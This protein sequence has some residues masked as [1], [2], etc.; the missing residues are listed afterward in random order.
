MAARLSRSNGGSACI[1]RDGHDEN[2]KDEGNCPPRIFHI[3]CDKLEG[4]MDSL[5]PMLSNGKDND[6]NEVSEFPTACGWMNGSQPI[7]G[8][9]C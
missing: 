5:D 8:M 2:C 3:T 9:M 1:Y 7:C 4:A 6:Y